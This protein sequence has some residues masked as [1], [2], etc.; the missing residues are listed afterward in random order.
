MEDSIYLVKPPKLSYQDVFFSFCGYSRT[1]KMHSFGPAVRDVHL[2]HIII[3]GKGY[4]SINN[5]KYFL[6][7]GEGFMIPPNVS[8]FYQADEKNPWSYIWMGIGG[9]LVQDYLANLSLND[10]HLSFQVKD[11]DRFK[12]IVFESF[13][14]EKDTSLNELCLQRQAFRFLEQ[15]YQSMEIH[16]TRI[17]TKKM[18]SYVA[19][20]LQLINEA[21]MY[22]ITINKLANQLAVHPSYLSRL[23]KADIGLSIKEYIMEL[24]ITTSNDLLTT[25]DD[26]IQRIS[27]RLGFSSLQAFSKAFKKHNGVAPTEYRQQRIGIGG[28]IT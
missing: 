28:E 6:K 22:N 5:T 7:E 16:Q 14:Y 24:R 15:L 11:V 17:E 3:S 26:S 27:E 19:K 21:P 1:E 4:Y 23:F 10:E 9:E 13:A 18:N 12:S 8:T 2:I 20:S 25:T